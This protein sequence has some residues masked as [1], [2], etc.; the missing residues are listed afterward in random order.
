MIQEH[1]AGAIIVHNGKYLL[2]KYKFKT[3]YWDFPR[4]NIEAGETEEEA[5]RREIREETGITEIIFVPDFKEQ[6]GWFY[7]KDDQQVRKKVTF[8]LCTTNRHHVTLSKE[9]IGSAWL[10]FD[11]AIEQLTYATAK[12]VLV[13]AHALVQHFQN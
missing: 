1:S 8:F 3:V 12:K 6:V 10:S 7:K 5:A 13:K 9:H 2:L 4:G 11:E